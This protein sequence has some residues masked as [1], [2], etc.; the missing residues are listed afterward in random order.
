MSEDV[1]R[2]RYEEPGVDENNDPVGG[3]QARTLLR[4]RAVAPGASRRN[5]TTT[6]NGESI[7]MTV[8]FTPAPDLRDD[9]ELEI[10]GEVFKI[11]TA[12]W[13]S[14]FGSGRSGLEAFALIDR[15]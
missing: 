1:Y 5:A 6:R 4:A 12:R 7:A 8:Y 13:E 14:A 2:I 11:R 10:R 3:G 9:D 15:G